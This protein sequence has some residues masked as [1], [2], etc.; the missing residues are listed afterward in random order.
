[1]LISD[2]QR[3][4]RTVYRGGFVGQLVSALVWFASAAL[5]TFVDPVTGCWALALGGVAI[6]P[7]TQALLRLAGGP[8]ALARQNPLGG[9]GMQVA[10]TVPLVLPVAGAAALHRPGWFYPA[11][12]V[13]VGAHSL[14]FVFMYGMKTFAGLAA[15][16]TGAGLAL[17][18]LA[19]EAVVLGGW[20]G[21]GIL[22]VFAFLLLGAYKA[23]A[24]SVRP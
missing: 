1:M 22:L 3:E 21:G 2:A 5:A 4:V 15:A 23:G 24:E 11:C 8:A 12:L 18:L 19:P 6:F 16:L 17:G 14:P 20:V 13:I 7:L 9:L 10:F